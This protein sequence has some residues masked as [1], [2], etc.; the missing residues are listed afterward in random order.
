M[1]VTCQTVAQRVEAYLRRQM[2]LDELVDWSED[3]IREADFDDAG[4]DEIRAALARL[5]LA[6]VRAFGLT[7]DDCEDILRRL[8]YQADIRIHA[9]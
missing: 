9:L 4:L 8:G 3:A 5:G 7:W 6:D 1:Q 2:T